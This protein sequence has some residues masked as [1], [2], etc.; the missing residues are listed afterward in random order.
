ME[1]RRIGGLIVLIIG[2]IVSFFSFNFFKK[3]GALSFLIIG[4][5][6]FVLGLIIFL[7]KNEDKIEKIKYKGG[8]K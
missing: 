3:G 6:I 8:K 1:K 2:F 7:N 5:L 4:F